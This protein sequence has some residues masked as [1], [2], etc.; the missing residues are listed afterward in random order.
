MKGC[1]YLLKNHSMHILLGYLRIK[2]QLPISSESLKPFMTSQ[3]NQ[4]ALIPWL[5]RNND[6]WKGKFVHFVAEKY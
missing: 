1:Q 2:G 4:L 3:Q 6:F 5:S